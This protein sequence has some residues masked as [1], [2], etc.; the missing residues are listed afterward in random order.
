MN[1]TKVYNAESLCK[2]DM[3]FGFPVNSLNK[4]VGNWWF[5]IKC[6]GSQKTTKEN[7]RIGRERDIE[8]SVL[9]FSPNNK[10]TCKT[11]L[12]GSSVPGRGLLSGQPLS[13]T[14]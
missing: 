7:H 5:C 10:H 1:R 6:N 4:P 11:I 14:S 9:V 13:S 2:G 12:T 8:K 3:V